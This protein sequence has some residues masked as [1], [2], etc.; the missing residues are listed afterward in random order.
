M[1]STA[2]CGFPFEE[3]RSYLIYSRGGRGESKVY[4][5]DGSNLKED[6]KAQ[7]KELQQIV[8]EKK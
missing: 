7:I 6:A 2:S 8:E 3:G 4:L 5:C 1:G